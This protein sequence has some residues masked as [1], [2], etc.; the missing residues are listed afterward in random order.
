[1]DDAT[2]IAAPTRANARS[3]PPPG[4][5]D[6]GAVYALGS[7]PAERERLR[8][9]PA[10][11][12]E[13]SQALLDRTGIAPG[14][15]AIDLG[16][17]PAGIL[18]L[19]AERVGPAGRV[20]GLDINPASIAQA[21]ELTR[22]YRQVELVIGDARNT[23][24]PSG[25]YDL[26]HART[27]LVN[28]PDPAAVV[29]EMVRLAKPGGWVAVLEPDSDASI[30]YPPHAA[31]DRMTGIWLQAASAYGLDVRIGRRL[32]ELLREAGLTGIGVEARAHIYPQ[33]HSRRA[34]RADL[35]RSMHEQIVAQG[36]AGEQELDEVERAVRKHLGRSDT[37]VLP[38]LL[39]LVWGRKLG[40][41]LTG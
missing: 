33:G 39:F 9:Q 40:G 37:L 17:G 2:S 28:A 14:W 41:A 11:L 35:L 8:R 10:E 24:L 34:I 1:M 4:G 5:G 36:I 12:R 23:S 21:R 13:D 15:S 25:S 16:C 3:A 19:L 18:D 20:T 38:N 7:S 22:R 26:V 31:W 6:L 30:C 32:P 29:T 27:L